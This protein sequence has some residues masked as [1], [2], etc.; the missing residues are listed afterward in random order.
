MIFQIESNGTNMENK[1]NKNVKCKV[2][3]PQTLIICKVLNY[4]LNFEV[5]NE[6]VLNNSL[7]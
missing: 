3:T 6:K 7:D 1:T 4:R 5:E 2:E